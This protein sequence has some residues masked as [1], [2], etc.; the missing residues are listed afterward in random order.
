MTPRRRAALLLALG[1]GLCACGTLRT[2][3][4]ISEQQTATELPFLVA[5]TTTRA[6]LLLR[7]GPPWRSFEDDSIFAWRVARTGDASAEGGLWR[8]ARVHQW[9]GLPMGDWYSA[10]SLI[11]VF[12]YDVVDRFA[13]VRVR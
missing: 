2:G 11:V 9:P 13:L 1:A 12:S 3:S 5:G 10:C 4:R 7:L 8:P 6:D